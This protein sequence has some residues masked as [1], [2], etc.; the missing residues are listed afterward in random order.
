MKKKVNIILMIVICLLIIPC[1][2]KAATGQLKAG[3]IEMECI[4]DNG[5][6]ITASYSDGA[7]MLSYS[8]FKLANKVTPPY[9]NAINAFFKE[10]EFA[11]EILQKAKCP[12]SI[13]LSGVLQSDGKNSAGFQVVYRVSDA[14]KMPESFLKDKHIPGFSATSYSFIDFNIDEGTI[15]SNRVSLWGGTGGK[16]NAVGFS[17]RLVSERIYFNNDVE[18]KRKWAFKTEGQQ[19]ASTPKYIKISEYM[20]ESNNRV[21]FAEKDN[22]ITNIAISLQDYNEEYIQFICF[23]PSVKSIKNDRNE[24]AYFY[25]Q[26]Q[27][28]GSHL[29]RVQKEYLGNYGSQF[30]CTSSSGYS[31]G[32]SLYKE[33][34]FEDYDANVTTSTSICEVMPETALLISTVIYYLGILVPV[35]LIVLTAIDIT[36]L[37]ISGNLDEELPK[38]KKILITRFIIAIC[39]FFIPIFIEIFVSSSYG[40]DFGDISCLYSEN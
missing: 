3:D 7:Y 18:P 27:H 28:M 40:M 32:Y 14:A 12:T 25:N 8:E 15:L 1:F 39:F 9:T 11:K 17:F 36:K 34:S 35:L 21:K 4:Y 38:R 5:A 37:V 22:F 23:S 24:M 20:T 13:G 26:S 16:K 29:L 33:T 2:V 19:A 30:G 31:S 6:L 10:Q